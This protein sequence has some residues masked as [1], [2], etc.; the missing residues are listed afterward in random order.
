MSI[1]VP[2]IE[3]QVV[4]FFVPAKFERA[5]YDKA[6]QLVSFLNELTTTYGKKLVQ[7]KGSLPELANKS[8]SKLLAKLGIARQW[9]GIYNESQRHY[10]DSTYNDDVVY[11]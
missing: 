2:A 9:Q 11:F 3:G 6:M 4:S 10:L 8:L 5:F 7:K 1:V